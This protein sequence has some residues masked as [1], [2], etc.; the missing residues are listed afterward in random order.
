V[1]IVIEEES[2]PFQV[3]YWTRWDDVCWDDA[4]WLLWSPSG[5]EGGYRAATYIICF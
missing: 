3:S 5:R 1:Q 4:C 2:P